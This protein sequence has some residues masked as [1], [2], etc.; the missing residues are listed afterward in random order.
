M[1]GFLCRPMAHARHLVSSTSPSELSKEVSVKF[2]RQAW[3]ANLNKQRRKEERNCLQSNHTTSRNSRLWDRKTQVT[4]HSLS[5]RRNRMRGP[6][7]AV[8]KLSFDRLSPPASARR[9]PP[10]QFS[11]PA[12]V[13]ACNGPCS[14]RFANA[15]FPQEDPGGA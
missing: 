7:S 15:C 1:T 3:S 12:P 14:P 4:L 9:F 6:A 5:P 10:R 11:P 2:L 8:P 13:R